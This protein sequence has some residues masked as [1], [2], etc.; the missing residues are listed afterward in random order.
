MNMNTRFEL[1]VHAIPGLLEPRLI[2]YV[3]GEPSAVSSITFGQTA[4]EQS[5]P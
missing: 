5:P 4:H 3:S 2:K 1:V